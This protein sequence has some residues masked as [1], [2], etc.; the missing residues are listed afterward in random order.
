METFEEWF[1]NN[2]YAST[3]EEMNSE[4]WSDSPQYVMAT[5]EMIWDH[6]QKKVLKL[7][8]QLKRKKGEYKVTCEVLQGGHE[9]ANKWA[10]RFQKVEI[11]LK[12]ACEIIDAIPTTSQSDAGDYLLF[13]IRVDGFIE[14]N[15]ERFE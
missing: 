6:Q 1:D 14:A 3:Y 4:E 12:E 7:E 9:D 8:A 11:Q 5:L 13:L 15:P 10:K 2:M